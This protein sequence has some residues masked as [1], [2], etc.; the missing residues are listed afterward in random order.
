VFEAQTL[1][2]ESLDS[3]ISA[4]EDTPAKPPEELRRMVGEDE[5]FL[6]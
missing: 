1:W 2:L 6:A 4:P 5:I 3:L